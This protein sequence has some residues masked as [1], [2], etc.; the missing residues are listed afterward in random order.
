LAN[1]AVLPI[2]REDRKVG[3][4]VPIER[5]V[6]IVLRIPA[7]RG[8]QTSREVRGLLYQTSPIRNEFVSSAKLSIERAQLKLLQ[9]T[10]AIEHSLRG[11]QFPRQPGYK[12]PP[13]SW[14][15]FPG[16]GFDLQ[17]RSMTQLRNRRNR[18]LYSMFRR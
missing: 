16:V 8:A 18:F 3:R 7:G 1:G 15:Y 17:V 2:G 11:I 5:I 10:M 14:Q 12:I 9:L 13:D 6:P 4:T